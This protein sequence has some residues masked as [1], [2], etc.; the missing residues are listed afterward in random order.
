MEFS[1][2]ITCM[3]TDVHRYIA[4]CGKQDYKDTGSV[5]NKGCS[6]DNGKLHDCG[7]Y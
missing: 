3:D 5:D 6:G 1:V 2:R 4:V 7:D